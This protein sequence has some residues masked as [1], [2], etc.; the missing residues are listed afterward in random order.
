MFLHELW[1]TLSCSK[2]PLAK[3]PASISS[4]ALSTVMSGWKS[5]SNQ[6]EFLTASYCYSQCYD[7]WPGSYHYT[8]CLW[9]NFLNSMLFFKKTVKFLA[10]S[11]SMAGFLYRR[12]RTKNETK[13]I[14]KKWRRRKRWRRKCKQRRMMKM[15]TKKK[16]CSTPIADTKWSNFGGRFHENN[17]V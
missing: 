3:P 8:H 12:Y 4:P 11:P 17:C 7:S 15:R 1:D 14:M 16:Q 13:K 10:S 2:Q 5:P 9:S 6:H